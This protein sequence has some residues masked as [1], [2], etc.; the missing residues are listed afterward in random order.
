ML[1]FLLHRIARLQPHWP[2][3]SYVFSFLPLDPKED[4]DANHSALNSFHLSRG[5]GTLLSP[6]I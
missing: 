6:P 3:L 2:Y 5:N 1:Q 4:R